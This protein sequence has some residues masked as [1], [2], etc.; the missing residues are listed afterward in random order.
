MKDI[1]PLCVSPEA[2]LRE[3]MQS[4]NHTG[5]G[6]ALVVDGDRHLLGVITDGD[7]R[8]AILA[9]LDLEVSAQ[10]ML[11]RNPNSPQPITAPVASTH[12]ALIE[13]VQATHVSPHTFGGKDEPIEGQYAPGDIAPKLNGSASKPRITPP[14]VLTGETFSKSTA[15][16]CF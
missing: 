4:I 14:S 5:R 12:S 9:G 10:I 16:N 11:G 2:S 3:V 15:S 8:R 6:V 7:V 13:L 1:T